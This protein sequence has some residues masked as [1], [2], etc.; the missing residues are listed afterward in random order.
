M[1]IEQHAEA[2]LSE[3]NPDNDWSP[4]DVHLA[5]RSLAK[6]IQAAIDEAA[7][8]LRARIAKLEGLGPLIEE[9]ANCK[10]ISQEMYECGD[11]EKGN[12]YRDRE[13]SAKSQINAI[14]KGGAP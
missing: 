10:A 5:R 1:S 13:I 8:T 14:L 2:A 11:D 4:Q 3:I 9:Y 6:H 12:K 7:A